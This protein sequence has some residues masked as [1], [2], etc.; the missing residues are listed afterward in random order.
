MKSAQ[1]SGKP[2]SYEDRRETHGF[3]V[4]SLVPS[5][6]RAAFVTFFK[7]HDA[8]LL[9]RLAGGDAGKRR[10]RDVSVVSSSR[11]SRGRAP[12]RAREK[13]RRPEKTSR[14]RRAGEDEFPREPLDRGPSPHVSCQAKARVPICAQKDR[15]TRVLA[16]S[17]TGAPRY[18]REVFILGSRS[19]PFSSQSVADAFRPI[20]EN[21]KKPEKTQTPR[22][23]ARRRGVK[24]VLLGG[25]RSRFV[26]WYAHRLSLL[27][28]SLECC[29]HSKGRLFARAARRARLSFFFRE[30]K[31]KT[32]KRISAPFPSDAA[33][34]QG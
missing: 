30:V 23:R 4:T 25:R 11:R 31:K 28:N 27:T 12:R 29:R 3:L 15:F 2:G 19:S 13:N 14:T 8:A 32:K 20:R 7:A 21:P 1:P 6:G 9:L 26:V 10:V 16:A 22:P 17:F 5:E 33:S 24:P 18:T 34:K